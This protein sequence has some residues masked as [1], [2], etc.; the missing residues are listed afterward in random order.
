MSYDTHLDTLWT[1]LTITTFK[2]DH[3]FNKCYLHLSRHSQLHDENV[4]NSVLHDNV[5]FVFMPF[6]TQIQHQPNENGFSGSP[7]FFLLPTMAIFIPDEG[8]SIYLLLPLNPPTPS[9]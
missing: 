1:V 3:K 7:G 4:L 2:N 8:A 9:L 6:N 5:T